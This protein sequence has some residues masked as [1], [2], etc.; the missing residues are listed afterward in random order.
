MVKKTITPKNIDEKCFQYAIYTG[1]IYKQI[2]SHPERISEIKIFIN[3][4][5]WKEKDFLLHKNIGKS[6]NKVINQ[7]PLM[8]YTYLKIMK[9]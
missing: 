4:Y 6:L 3:Q 1:L 9:K 8:C 2:K 7:L 5:D